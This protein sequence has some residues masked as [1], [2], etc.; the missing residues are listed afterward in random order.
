MVQTIPVKPANVTWTDDQWKAIYASGQDTLVSAA[1]GS[2]K[3]AVLINRMI[4]KVVAT[5]NPI[6]VDE[7]LVVTFT[8]ASAAEMRHRMAEALEKAIVENPTSSHLRRQLSLI[9]K[10]QISTLHSF[11]L[12]IVKQY[13]YMLEIDPGFRIANEA[14]VAL[15][16][17][18][19]LADVL[20]AAYDTPDEAKAHALYRLIDSFTSDRDDQAIEILMSKLYDTSRV[21]AE[22]FKWL[23]SLPEG[24]KLA[25]EVTIDDL[26]LSQYVKLTVKHSLE[27]AF[28]LISEMRE[29]TLKPDGP[30]PYAETAEIDFAMIQEGIRISREGSW[31]ELYDYFGTVKWTK[32]KS[33]KKDSLANPDLQDLAKKKREAAKKIV[34]KMKETY[35]VRTPARLLEEIRLMAPAIETLVELTERFSEQFSMAKLERGIIDFSDL[36]HFA[37]QILTVEVDGGLQPSPIALDFKKRFKEVLV[38]EYQ[39]TNMLQETILQLVK[40]GD[41]Q[42]GNL[43]MVGD[44][45]QSIY[46]FR[47][48]EPKLFM[49]KYG[50]FVEEPEETGMRID[51][52]ANFR[53]R[54]EVL[55]GTN[56]VF[57]QI[58]GERVGEI[59]YDDNASLKPAA[60]YD[61][62]EVPVELTILHPPQEEAL[63]EEE[64]AE[65]VASEASELEELKKSQYEAR[66]II[67]RIQQ[68]M[69]EGTTVYDTKSGTER[70]LKYRD[71]VI[72]MRSMTWSADLVEE[73]KLAGIPLYAESSKGYF[74][75]LEVM[76]ML[77]TLKV[78]DNPY[79]DIP[80]ASVLRAP[81]V[82]LTE[83][84]LAKIRLAE[85]KAPFYDA[86]K[87]FVRSEGRGVQSVTFEKLQRFMLQFENWRDL[88]RR[89]SLSDLIWKIYLDTHYYEMVGAMPNGR[90]RQANLRVLHDRALMYE[91]TAFRGL[92][93]FLR[94]IDRMRTRGDDLGT[95]KSIGEKDDVV[96]LVTIHSSKGLEFPVVFVAGMGRPFNKMDFHNP[97]LFDQDYG[98]A[99]KAIDPE[100]R[101]TY[102]SLPFLAMKEKKELE[103]RAEEMRVL[104]VA[105]TRAKERLV[106]VGSVKNWEKTREKWQDAQSLPLDAPLQEYL[107]ARANSYFDWVGPAVARHID[108]APLADE[109]YKTVDN[110]S[111]WFVQAMSTLAFDYETPIDHEELQKELATIEDQELFD[112]INRRFQAQYKF[113]KSTL[114]RSKTSVSEI[115]R[116][117]NL[118]RQEEPEYFFTAPKK[119]AS[120]IA[121]RPTFLQEKRMTGAEIGTVVHTIMQHVP[122]WGFATVQEVKTFVEDLV[123]KQLLTEAEA[124]VVPNEKIVHFFTTDIGQRFKE[125]KQIRREMPFTISHV[126]EDGD[127]QIIQGIVDCLFEDAQGNWVLLDY[128]TDHI[129]AHFAEE[130]A[131]SKEILGRYAVQLRV[132]SEAIESILHIKVSEKVLYL[133]DIGRE[134]YAE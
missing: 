2:G 85:P 125:A 19:V 28:V 68:L 17:D 29:I 80:L 107:R 41:E 97:Y 102:T 36:E 106:L 55:H 40:S 108:F 25:D 18:D 38:D 111:R 112:E 34:N 35:F 100:D 4:E 33:V 130:P 56:Y 31:Q 78:I 12:A 20:E 9:N 50:N 5:E 1:A 69:A 63:D 59:D 49:R 99:V 133:F 96:R 134:L 110:P 117:E 79:Q 103:M 57:A 62:K 90:Q 71:I 74:D 93:R 120:T 76:I 77:N 61:D 73:F 66:F 98:L 6:N 52:N 3:T 75:A 39:D 47:L 121:P 87:Q 124:K 127:A 21:H 42:D 129:Q 43:F 7:L 119:Q 116:I 86:L 30:A 32:L 54:K 51:L 10:A 82:G 101:I 88:A 48:A 94:F 115:K 83:N 64:Q 22:P 84:E 27:E 37:L 81:F 109:P 105:M 26:E 114:K 89:G 95:A 118:Q 14:E 46:R 16:R 128:K 132:Y 8:N 45:K 104:Y 72:L 67:E 58:M 44:V 23:R 113:Q 15:L 60:P 131:L 123:A 126:D 91:K 65:S 11:C 92:F 122:K 70:P 13:A 53:S 24:Y